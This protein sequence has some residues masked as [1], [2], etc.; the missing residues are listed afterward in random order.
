MRVAAI[1]AFAV[2]AGHVQA[3]WLESL[4]PQLPHSLCSPCVQLGSQGINTLLNYLLNAG[5]VSSCSK[6]CSNLTNKA[7][8]TACNLACDLVGIKAFMA[9]LNHTDLD[10]IYFCEM[11]TACEAGPDNASVHLVD[12]KATP[13]A[14]SKGDTVQMLCDI[15]APWMTKTQRLLIQMLFLLLFWAR[16]FQKISEELCVY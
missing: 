9:A 11:I 5:V 13:T 10:P 7:E 6:L 1:A 2:A 15:N 14:V 3:S 8:Q 12:A 4:E 16:P